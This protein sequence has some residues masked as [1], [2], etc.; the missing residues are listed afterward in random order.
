MGTLIRP[1]MIYGDGTHLFS[2]IDTPHSADLM[3]L[4]G[5]EVHSLLGSTDSAF[6]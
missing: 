4:G 3:V 6:L 5:G 2:A 1:F